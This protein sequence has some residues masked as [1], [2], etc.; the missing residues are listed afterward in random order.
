[1]NIFSATCFVVTIAQGITA[2]WGGASVFT[3]GAGVGVGVG[4]IGQ[5]FLI[6]N[7]YCEADTV[8]GQGVPCLTGALGMSSSGGGLEP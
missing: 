2:T 7:K 5:Y 6:S 4:G 3:L 1:M 8:L